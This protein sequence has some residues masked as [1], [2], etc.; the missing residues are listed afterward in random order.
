MSVEAGMDGMGGKRKHDKGEA[1]KERVGRKGQV[2][3]P[4]PVEC[5]DAERGAMMRE[6]TVEGSTEHGG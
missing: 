2:I 3:E 5:R 1:K 4:H 6:A